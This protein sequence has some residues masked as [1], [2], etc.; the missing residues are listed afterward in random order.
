MIELPLSR[1]FFSD[2]FAN[3][4]AALWM[5]LGSRRAFRF[6]SPS[7][8]QLVFLAILAVLANTLFSWLTAN[9]DGRFNSQGLA[10]YLL[11]PFISLIAGIFIAQRNGLGRMMLVPVILWLA[12]D[13]Y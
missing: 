10:S 12:A 3:Q 6:V 5:L 13:I 2:L 9:G 8:L 11:W 7:A 1:S 4:K